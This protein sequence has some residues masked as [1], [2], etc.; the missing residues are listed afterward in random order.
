MSALNGIDRGRGRIERKRAR[1]GAPAPV[2]REQP[3]LTELGNAQ[4]FARMHGHH[5]R[6]VQTWGKWLAWDGQRWKRDEFGAEMKAAK[7]V[8]ESIYVDAASLAQRAATGDERAGSSAEAM[9]KWGKASSKASALRAMLTLAQSEESIAVAA[10]EFDRD[11]FALNVQNGTLDLRTGELRPH[12]QMD[13]ITKLASTNYNP[14]ATC[15]LWDAFLS[16]VL[17]D[18]EV[19][20]FVQRFVGYALTGDITE[21][22]LMF[23]YGSGANGKSVLLDVLLAILG[24]YGLRAAPD[25]VLAKQ[26]ESHPTELADLE[27]RRLV[28]CSEIDPGR[29]WAES[30]IKRIT[31]DTTITAR[32]MKQDFYTF[33]ATHKLV[34]AANTRPIVRGT[35][36]GIWRRM[37]LVPFSVTIPPKERDKGLVTR[38]LEEERPGILAW[39]VRGCLARQRDGIGEPTAVTEATESYR[40]EQDILGI[41]IAEECVLLPDAF[42]ATTVLYDNYVAWCQRTRREPWTRD[43]MRA[44]LL[45]RPGLTDRRTTAARGVAGIGLVH[46]GGPEARA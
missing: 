10:G 20:A 7:A 22:T 38:L 24:D 45:E 46:R 8:A 16:R 23:A 15:P 14:S 35:D 18:E 5:L 3:R 32:R 4:R 27:G 40:N 11:R 43:T 33:P 30:T 1:N 39:A 12:Q 31:G 26:G 2:D 21:Q 41:W 44:R 34:I 25:L 36:Q 19:R 37:R 6:Y 9:T 29:G 13:L 42:A 28:V 17:P